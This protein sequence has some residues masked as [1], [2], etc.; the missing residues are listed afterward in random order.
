MQILADE[1]IPYV[2]EA[3]S[4][5]GEVQTVEGR[6]LTR[7]DLVNKEILLVRSVTPVNANLLA[8]TRVRFVGTATIGYDHVDLEYLQEQGIGFTSAPGSNATA[9]AEYVISAL[10]IISERQGFELHEKTVGI[11]GCGNVGSR[12]WQKLKALGVQCLL[13]DPPLQEKTGSGGFVDLETVLSAQI[14]TLHV[15]LEKTGKYPTYHLVNADF[16]E[17]LRRDVIFINTSRGNV[18]DENALFKR[19]NAHPTMIAVLDVWKNE[20]RI[21]LFLLQR[22]ALGTPHIAG[23]S[24]DGKVRGTEMI[25]T[26]TCHFFNQSPIWQ[27]QTS[28]PEPPLT[29]LFF[30]KTAEDSVA[31]RTAVMACYDVR[32]DDTMLRLI[33][34]SPQSHTLFDNLRKNYPIRREFGCVEVN[35]PMEKEDLAVKLRG[36]GF[37][38]NVE[39]Q[40]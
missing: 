17:K 5:L 22:V 4:S 33:V 37:T 35:L 6:R 25:Y 24:L 20:P 36:L 12:V 34:Q 19:L 32:R 21:N 31:L 15:P 27:V 18:I 40:S 30:S 28:L 8:G 29:R 2:Q 9:A 7:A 16:L 14:I 10:L 26:T 39:A 1:N 23:Y 13:Y 3:F 38:V 11:I